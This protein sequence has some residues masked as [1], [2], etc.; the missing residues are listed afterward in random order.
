MFNNRPF[1][2]SDR[3]SD[4]IRLAISEI[5]LKN[6]SISNSGLIT[7]TKVDVSK[8]LRYAKIFFSHINTG[9]TSEDLEKKLNQNKSKIRYHMGNSLAAQY[10]PQINF[11]FDKRY[12]KSNRIENL[13]NKVNKHDK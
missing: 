5:L 1:K 2:R 8:D 6:I 12:D 4:K 9:F 7:I 3:V 13:L 10:V 11:K